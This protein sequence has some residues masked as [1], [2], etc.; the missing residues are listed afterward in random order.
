M[1]HTQS[2]LVASAVLEVLHRVGSA[3]AGREHRID[4]QDRTLVD[5]AWK[6]LVAG[7]VCVWHSQRDRLL[8][9]IRPTLYLGLECLCASG[10][11]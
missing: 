4:D 3:S 8:H 11:P 7:D 6:L 2:D 5:V 10:T 1:E 9:G